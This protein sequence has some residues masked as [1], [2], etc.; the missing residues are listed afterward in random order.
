[1]F[2]LD[3]LYNGTQGAPKVAPQS[4]TTVNSGNIFT[5]FLNE[6][7]VSY[8]A[9]EANQWLLAFTVFYSF[10][11][12]MDFLFFK[13]MH[14]EG[15]LENEQRGLESLGNLNKMWFAY[16]IYLAIWSVAIFNTGM[17][18]TIFEYL[19]LV[20]WFVVLVGVN[21]PMIPVFKGIFG[22]GSSSAGNIFTQIWGKVFGIFTVLGQYL[23]EAIGIV[24]P[25][26]KK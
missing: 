10:W 2:A 1:M 22:G 4:T 11:F 23:L 26:V 18:R 9:I 12:L 25:P 14:H 16:F 3:D 19:S 17:I 7:D 21:L 15:E 5:T 20:V 13:I 8:W 24:E 6:F